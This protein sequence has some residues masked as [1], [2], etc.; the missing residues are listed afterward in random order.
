MYHKIPATYPATVWVDGVRLNQN[1]YY[2]NS[3]AHNSTVSIYSTAIGNASYIELE[4]YKL[5]DINAHY[6]LLSLGEMHDST[7]IKAN[8]NEKV[9][10]EIS[11]QN[12]IV[13]VARDIIDTATGQI[14]RKYLV[15]SA[16]ELYWL[17]IGHTSYNKGVPMNVPIDPRD[18]AHIYQ[19][20]VIKSLQTTINTE[21]GEEE[22]DEVVIMSDEENGRSRALIGETAETYAGNVD[23]LRTFGDQEYFKVL[24]DIEIDLRYSC[25][26]GLTIGSVHGGETCPHCNTVVEKR[27]LNSYFVTMLREGYY[28]RDRKRFF[29]YL[30]MTK[31]APMV[32]ITPITNYFANKDVMVKNT[33][34]YFAKTYSFEMLNGQVIKNSIIINEFEFDP[35]PTKYRLYMDGL[36]LDYDYDFVSS[37]NMAKHDETYYMG[38]PFTIYVRKYYDPNMQHVLT[39]EYLP[40]RYQ[41]VHRSAETDGIITIDDTYLRPYDPRNFDVYMDGKLLRDDQIEVITERRI[42][43]KP[44]IENVTTLNYAPIISVYEKMHDDDVFDYIWREHKTGF[45]YVDHDTPII[46]VDDSAYYGKVKTVIVKDVNDNPDDESG[47]AHRFDGLYVYFDEDDNMLLDLT[48]HDKSGAMLDPDVA[49]EDK[50]VVVNYYTDESTDP[51]TVDKTELI[52]PYDRTVSI[53][54]TTGKTN[55]KRYPS[56]PTQ[57][58]NVRMTEPI[59]YSLDEQIIRTDA[60]YRQARTP[61][62]NSASTIK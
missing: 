55:I 42:A 58:I 30:P 59:K 21:T 46:E 7:P 33:D 44:I 50:F 20:N 4:I 49:A 40:Y 5:R 38:D 32:Y 57:T 34:V 16:Y 8:A 19:Y 27:P 29:E 15:P 53:P 12:M 23:I 2:V 54:R 22:H 28:N 48:T 52:V 35:S 37:V 61:T 11:P 36:L 3:S 6:K 31:D 62:Y 41:L 51:A 39:F 43:I 1:M 18:A 9:W 25:K 45:D 17:I 24:E 10:D 56:D 13:A 14:V 26:C 47:T 60:A